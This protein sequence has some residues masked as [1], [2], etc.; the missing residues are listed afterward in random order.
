MRNN[1]IEHILRAELDNYRDMDDPA[2]RCASYGVM[3]ATRFPF[4]QEIVQTEKQLLLII[5][6]DYIRRIY[7]DGRTLPEN[8]EPS[9]LGYSVGHWEGSK[10]VVETT[11]LTENFVSAH[12]PYSS[13]TR[14]VEHYYTTGDGKLILE[15]WLHDAKYY[16]RPLYSLSIR[17]KAEDQ[18]IGVTG[19]DPYAFFRSLAI[20]GKLDELWERGKFRR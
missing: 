2:L 5:G 8:L 18:V 20:H 3:R 17:V 1:S 6:G 13:D 9:S 12:L 19:C 16:N 11:G 4:P 10:L 14:L 15:M 7:L